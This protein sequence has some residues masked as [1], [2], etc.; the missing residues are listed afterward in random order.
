MRH[1]TS[2]PSTGWSYFFVCVMFIK[3]NNMNGFDWWHFTF[4]KD[5][6]QVIALHRKSWGAWNRFT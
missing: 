6:T 4:T 1:Q 2:P 5:L 3:D